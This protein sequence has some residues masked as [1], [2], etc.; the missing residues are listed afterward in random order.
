MKAMSIVLNLRELNSA[1]QKSKKYELL[2]TLLTCIASTDSKYIVIVKNVNEN[3][4]YEYL[5]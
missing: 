2:E 5:N 1:S 4:F 3:V